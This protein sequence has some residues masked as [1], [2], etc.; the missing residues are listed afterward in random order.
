MSGSRQHNIFY[1][2]VNY[3]VVD[4][5]ER[6]RSLLLFRFRIQNSAHR[7]NTDVEQTRD[8][9]NFHTSCPKFTDLSFE[10]RID[11][12]RCATTFLVNKSLDTILVVDAVPST[13]TSQTNTECSGEF[14][15]SGKIGTQEGNNDVALLNLVADS[16]DIGRDAINEDV[17][18]C[19]AVV[20]NPAAL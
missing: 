20:N 2:T 4:L 13:H 16:I 6:H 17:T 11:F 19:I 7:P 9:V 18:I 14:K 3:T 10:L 5:K 15:F 1:L 8:L 12:F